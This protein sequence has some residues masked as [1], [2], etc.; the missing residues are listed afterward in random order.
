MVNNFKLL[1]NTYNLPNYTHPLFDEYKAFIQLSNAVYK[2]SSAWIE[3]G[4]I[5]DLDRA[6]R[7]L[8]SEERETPDR[9]QARLLRSRWSDAYKSAINGFT[10]ILAQF[11]IKPETLGWKN[12]SDRHEIFNNID[13]QGSSLAAFLIKCDRAAL[14]DGYCGVLVEFPR[15]PTDDEG[16]PIVVNAAIEREIGLRPYLTLIKREDIINW[17]ITRR[18]N[19]SLFLEK[20]VVRRIDEVPKG[21]YGV[22][23]KERFWEL[24]PGKYLVWE[25]VDD[26]AILI[27]EATTTL[28][29]IPLTFYPSNT[30]EPFEAMP[31]LYDLALDNIS[32]YQIGSDYRE[33]LHYLSLLFPVRK[34]LIDSQVG[35]N[36]PPLILSPGYII[37]LPTG[38]ELELK[39]TTGV[40]IEASRQALLDLQEAMTRRSLEFFGAATPT[41]TAT[42]ANLR[43]MSGRANLKLMATDKESAVEQIFSDWQ[44]WE[45]VDGEFDCGIVIDK[46]VFRTSLSAQEIATYSNLVTVGQ[47]SQ[48]AFI[49]LLGESGALPE[50]VNVE[51]EIQG[52]VA[53]GITEEE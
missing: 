50:S 45:N 5:T 24:T 17:R 52:A 18:L 22:E 36:L 46:S 13:M 41:M 7:F 43:A 37:D 4:K 15:Q 40:G 35:S 30:L 49:K 28:D 31:P 44:T 33:K 6:K 16:N 23:Y 11:T 48:E 9:Y 2:G 8:P 42:E 25:I 53:N 38:C 39:E 27:D 10:G 34:G 21:E 26:E 47:M 32:H 3:D 29:Y 51:E 19:G 20:L 1:N 14:L 12:E